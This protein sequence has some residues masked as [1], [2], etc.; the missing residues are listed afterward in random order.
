MDRNSSIGQILRERREKKGLLLRQ[1][2]ALLNIDSAILSK[3]ERG[4]RKARKEQILQLAEILDLNQED[5][6]VHYLSEKILYEIRDE[7]LAE[8]ALQVAERKLKY[9]AQKYNQD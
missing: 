4:E 2:A 1:V 9:N 8:K 3:I 5:L 7:Q 6:V